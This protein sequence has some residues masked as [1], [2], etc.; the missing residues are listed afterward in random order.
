M[1]WPSPDTTI[2]LLGPDPARSTIANPGNRSGHPAPRHADSPPDLG[3]FVPLAVQPHDPCIAGCRRHL[4]D[5]GGT[6]HLGLKFG[7]TGDFIGTMA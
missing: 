7:G 3:R 6:A 1:G 4:R 2:L 5:G